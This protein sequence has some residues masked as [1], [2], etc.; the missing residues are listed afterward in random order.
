VT[1]SWTSRCD[2]C[3]AML[4]GED[5]QEFYDRGWLDVWKSE[6]GPPL[7]FCDQECL[8]NYFKGGAE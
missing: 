4:T 1:T 8:V 2:H 3:G 6:D 7:E 5:R